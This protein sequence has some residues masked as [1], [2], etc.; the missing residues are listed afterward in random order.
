MYFK[1]IAAILS[2]V[3]SLCT[4]VVDVML[5]KP[6]CKIK[7]KFPNLIFL[8]TNFIIC[9]ILYGTYI[10]LFQINSIWFN[11]KQII[12]VIF[13]SFTSLPLIAV[14][15]CICFVNLHILQGSQ[16]IHTHYLS[17]RYFFLFFIWLTP[18]MRIVC[19]VY[20]SVTE[21]L[22]INEYMEIENRTHMIL[23]FICMGVYYGASIVICVILLVKIC[24]INASDVNNNIMQKM[25][26]M[27][28]GYLITMFLMCV[29]DVVIDYIDFNYKHLLNTK[30]ML[31]CIFAAMNPVMVYAFIWSKQIKENFKT[32]YCGD[33]LAVEDEENMEP[34]LKNE[35]KSE[36]EKSGKSGENDIL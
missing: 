28:Y 8:Y 15:F 26:R 22:R 29:V 34:L 21:Q 24:K 33:K 20:L 25:I 27:F 2:I 16:L 6:I 23:Y 32:L 35:E 7:Q 1:E 3:I 31:L 13:Q 18:F 12:I 19:I 17:L 30:I 10:I 4:I 14:S 5:F 9:S 36:N 11:I